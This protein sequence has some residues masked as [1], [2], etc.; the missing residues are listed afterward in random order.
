MENIT[1]NEMRKLATKESNEIEDI[2]IGIRARA[3]KG[4]TELY[5]SDYQIK[6]TTE[7]ELK[8][9]GFFI[10]SGGRYNEINILIRWD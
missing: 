5:L 7:K 4:H 8:K 10:E 2:L 6:D 3:E 9:R 1:A